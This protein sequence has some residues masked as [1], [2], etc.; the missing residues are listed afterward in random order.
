MRKHSTQTGVDSC[1]M[2]GGVESNQRPVWSFYLSLHLALVFFHQIEACA[3]CSMLNG[4]H[5]E[6]QLYSIIMNPK[7]LNE[8]DHTCGVV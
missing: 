7:M 1:K 4:K 8:G 3:D 5:E 2:P 6:A